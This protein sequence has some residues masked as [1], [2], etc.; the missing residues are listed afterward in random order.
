MAL[1]SDEWQWNPRVRAPAGFC[2]RRVRVPGTVKIFTY[3]FVGEHI[4]APRLKK[5]ISKV[6]ETINK[7]YE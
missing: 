4:G 7:K 1:G 5:I 3:A 6:Y 2:P